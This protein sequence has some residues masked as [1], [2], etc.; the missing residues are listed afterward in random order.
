MTTR[1]ALEALRLPELQ[2]RYAEVVGETTRSPNRTHLIRRIEEALASRPA[3]RPPPRGEALTVEQLQARYL[4]VVG[5]PTGSVSKAYLQWKIGEA[6]KGR[7]TVG[8]L[9]SRQHGVQ[10]CE[11]RVLPFRLEASVVD[12][13]DDAWRRRGA[14]NR[15]D[16]L[17]R[18]LQHDLEHLGDIEAARAL[19]GT[20]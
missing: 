17:R 6:T 8:P 10:A 5:R 9:P 11:V 12:L 13:V 18:A 2:A 4:E 15:T 1:H 19:E 7:V 14:A 3:R 16:F 20:Q